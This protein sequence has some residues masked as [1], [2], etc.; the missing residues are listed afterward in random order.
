MAIEKQY[1]LDV[2]AI[3]SHRHDNGADLW[4]TPDK[5]LIK[6]AP[7]STLESVLYL[8]ELGM[9]PTEPLLKETTELIFSTWQEDGRFKLYPQGSVYPCQTIHAANTLCHMGYASDL[10]LQ[11]TFQHLLDI[12]YI[13]GGWRCNKFSFGRGPETE[14]SNPLP[15]LNALSAFRFSDHFSNEPALDKAVDFLLEH[16]TIRK[17]IGPCHYGIGTLFMQVEYPFRNYN[18]FVYVYVLS[19]Y[20]R[21]KEDKRFLEALKTLE[22][23]MVDGQ[24]AVERI[25]PKLAG[26]SFCKKGKT[27]ALATIRYHEILRN[28]QIKR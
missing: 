17:P 12:Q 6:D 25:A 3:L 11:K 1:A 18:L 9:E 20:N 13:D 5:R 4:T 26:L 19:F 23:K 8:L 16:W 10:R 15:T 14:Y 28:L 27:S 24:I 7:F 21:A 22:S 2:E